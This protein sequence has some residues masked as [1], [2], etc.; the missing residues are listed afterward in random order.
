M[1]RPMLKRAASVE[2][3]LELVKGSQRALAIRGEDRAGL[4]VTDDGKAIQNFRAA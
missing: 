1:D 4:L 3:S 2:G